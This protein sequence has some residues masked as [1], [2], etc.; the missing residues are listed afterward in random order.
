MNNRKTLYP[1]SPE[2]PLIGWIMP[3]V[4]HY[5]VPVINKLNECMDF[6]LNIYSG[7]EKPGIG[8]GDSS[9]EVD[10]NVRKLFNIYMSPK[11]A[12]VLYSLGWARLIYDRCRVIIT[13]EASHN[14][15]NWLL[16]AG[17][18]LFG[19]KVVIMG[20]IK[21]WANTNNAV[22]KLR[23]LLVTQAD[24]VIAY[25]EEGAKQAKEWGVTK[26]RVISMGNT[27]DLNAIEFAKSSVTSEIVRSK[28]E[29]LGF[30]NAPV[31][32]FVGRP[33]PP[34]RLDLAIEATLSLEGSEHPVNLV[35]IG[36]SKDIETHKALAGRSKRIVFL[37]EILNEND[38]APY[39][40][41]SE[42]VI[43][44]GAVGL[45]INH[46]FAYDRPLITSRHAQHRPEIA[47]A[48][49]GCNTAFVEDLSA[50]SL[51]ETLRILH[52]DQGLLSRLQ[53]GAK[54][55]ATPG[56]DNMVDCIILALKNLI[57]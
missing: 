48:K 19:Y 56:M 7:Q 8:V 37:G 24:A 1:H 16:L 26:D 45:T 46:A 17:R 33:T 53:E 51:A 2:N 15:T 5:R 29:A 14:L 25:T 32:L 28:R 35:V 55:T 9:G 41:L 36:D 30:D 42:A 4:P 13:T 40:A 43:L 31:F 10:A 34:K 38:L 27:L 21:P 54:K 39:F 20:H 22:S 47:L 11:D 6:S 12:R 18:G 57:K 49:E 3:T 50:N 52:E 44:P 23:K